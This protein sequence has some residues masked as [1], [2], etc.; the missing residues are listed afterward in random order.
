MVICSLSRPQLGLIG[1]GDA[2]A[3]NTGRS[4]LLGEASPQQV[5][6]KMPNLMKLVTAQ[7]AVHTETTGPVGTLPHR[8]RQPGKKIVSCMLEAFRAA[9]DLRE[10]HSP[11]SISMVAAST[12]LTHACCYV[13]R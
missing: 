6:H 11:Y 9:A 2:A 3:T 7:T 12:L 10:P 4:T 1:H 13:A 5:R 8:R